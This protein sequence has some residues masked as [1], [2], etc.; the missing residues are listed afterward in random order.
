MYEHYLD[1]ELVCKS[2]HNYTYIAY[3][4]RH[5]TRYV[6]KINTNYRKQRLSF[7]ELMSITSVKVS[8][9]INY[10]LSS[11]HWYIVYYYY[12]RIRFKN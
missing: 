1:S 2:M 3:F 11:N 5:N 6:N 7:L 10:N 12:R 4:L 8:G 9:L